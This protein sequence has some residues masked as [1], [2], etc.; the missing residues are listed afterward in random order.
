MREKVKRV[1]FENPSSEQAIVYMQKH[2]A[3]LAVA[4]GH[5][6]RCYVLTF[7]CQQNVADSEKL[8]GIAVAMGYEIT[9]RPDEADLILVNTCAIREHAE[10]RALSI[11]G[12]FKHLKEKKRELIIGVCGC[13]VV[14]KHRCDQ[15]KKSYPYVDFV[16]APSALHRLPEQIVL[17]LKGKRRLFECEDEFAIAE[18][19]PMVRD[20]HYRAYV[21]IMYGCNNFCSYCIVP[22]VRGRERSRNPEDVIGEVRDLVKRGYKDITLLGQNVNSYGKGE[23]HGVD[24]AELLARLDAIEGDFVLRFMTSHPKDATRRLIDVMAEGKHIAHHFHLPLQSGNDRVLMAMNRHYDRET[25]LSILEYMRKK[26]PDIAVTTDI[27]VA[28]PGEDDNAFEDTLSML[29]IGKFDMIYSFIY[30]PRKGTPA[31]EMENKVPKEVAAARMERL[32]SVQ[33]GVAERIS[34]KLVGMDYRVLCDGPSKTD[35]GMLSGR[36]GQNKIIFWPDDGTKAGEWADIH[37]DRATP[38][39]LYGKRIGL[40]EEKKF[41]IKKSEED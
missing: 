27:I 9:E 40:E 33:E 16:L 35:E 32:L 37:I 3:A 12:Q 24:F 15:L 10:K 36:N 21:S 13:M 29:R 4:V 17:R 7:G 19:V 38:Y 34:Q 5:T 2:N 18:Q 28:F 14:Q 31:A 25:Y 6:P 26:I 1:V 8:A 23:E 41:I 22:Y 39:A 30:S 11:V 20:G